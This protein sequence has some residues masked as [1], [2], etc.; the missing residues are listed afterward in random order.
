MPGLMTRQHVSTRTPA[1]D[2]TLIWTI[3]PLK[4]WEAEWI[5]HLLSR[6]ITHEVVDS[7]PPTSTRCLVVLSDDGQSVRRTLQNRNY[8]TTRASTSSVLGL[9][10]LSDEWFKASVQY[11]DF[12]AFTI[13]LGHWATHYP[14]NVLT[15]PVGVSS[16]FVRSQPAH[17]PFAVRPAGERTHLWSFLGQIHSKP[18]REAMREAFADVPNGYVFETSRWNDPNRLTDVEYRRILSDSVFSLCP[19]GWS[20]VGH[21]SVDSFRTYESAE[22]GAIPIVDSSYY[23]DAFDAPFPVVSPDWREAPAIVRSLYANPHTLRSLQRRCHE[24]WMAWRRS[25]PAAVEAHVQQF[26]AAADEPAQ[27]YDRSHTTTSL[28]GTEW[29]E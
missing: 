14:D 28:N 18:T 25:A 22:A 7:S 3:D 29:S 8:L 17:E 26:T 23:R 15:L 6:L 5:R 11:Y 12:A 20:A 21:C 1:T 16:A 13:R 2:W 27:K 10:H 19:R 4:L 24:W 9:V